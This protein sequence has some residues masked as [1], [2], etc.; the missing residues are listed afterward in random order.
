MILSIPVTVRVVLGSTSLPVA[1]LMKLARG[2]VISLDQ[3]VG[4]PVDIVVNGRGCRARRDRGHR[5][6]EPAV[7]R[8]VAGDRRRL[9]PRTGGVRSGTT[10]CL[11]PS[12]ASEVLSGPE[13]AAAVLL[14]LGAPTAARLL[15][16]F[17]PPDL[18]VVARSAAGLGA[19]APVTLERLAEEF[20]ADFS[21]GVN[22]LGDM[23]QARDLL[24]EALPPR[25]GR[26][27]AR[28]IGRRGVRPMAGRSPP[29]PKARSSPSCWPK[30]PRP[31]LTSCPG[32]IP[33]SRPE[34]S[35]P[36]RAAAGMPRS[37]AWSRRRKSLLSP[38]TGRKGAARSAGSGQGVGR[39]RRGAPAHRRHHQQSRPRGGRGRHPRHRRGAAQGRRRHQRRCFSRSAICLD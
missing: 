37:A 35:A 36:F 7:R 30:S 28:R 3:R 8:V 39:R 32:S 17:D 4:D 27:T 19:V 15:K 33:R 26:R 6:I 2:S 34:S 11:R 18:K 21:A 24:A 16:H 12:N 38:P 9:E 25:R 5:R 10:G 22:L 13:K 14:M 20:A 1:S 23:S 31:R 29:L